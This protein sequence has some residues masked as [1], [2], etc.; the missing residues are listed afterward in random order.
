MLTYDCHDIRKDII[1]GK[2]VWIGMNV[3]ILPG[4]IIGD[5][6]I[7]GVCTTITKDILSGDIVVGSSQCIL[8][9]RDEKHTNKLVKNNQYLRV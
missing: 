5:G 9:H 7:V 1:I 3:Q 4:V 2:Y 8:G 6:A